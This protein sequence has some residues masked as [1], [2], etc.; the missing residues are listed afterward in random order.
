MPP[1]T[2]QSP[3]QQLKIVMRTTR[4]YFT[5]P[6]QEGKRIANNPH[7]FAI[8]PFK[9]KLGIRKTIPVIDPK[10]ETVVNLQNFYKIKDSVLLTNITLFQHLAGS[11]KSSNPIL[12]ANP[13][14][15]KE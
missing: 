6:N 5:N 3:S 2:K 9:G 15:P 11:P 8:L 10:E 12:S 13:T 14:F 4:Q 1:K 7:I